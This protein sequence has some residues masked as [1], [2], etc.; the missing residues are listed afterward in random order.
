MKKS[1]LLTGVII[2]A[3]VIFGCAPQASGPGID[4]MTAFT[5]AYSHAVVSYDQPSGTDGSSGTFTTTSTPLPTIGDE[6]E[7]HYVNFTIHY[8]GEIYVVSGTITVTDYAV[9]PPDYSL[10]F[11]AD[12]TVS[13]SYSGQID[14]DFAVAF[15]SVTTS[16]SAVGTITINGVAYPVNQFGV[17][18]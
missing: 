18:A 15:N 14:M 9:T 6:H 3:V 12:I 7:I 16:Y 17:A 13:G 1:I 5:A 11:V 10:S 2:A 4:E 8:G